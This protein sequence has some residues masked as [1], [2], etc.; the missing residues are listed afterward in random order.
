[1]NGNKMNNN[2][3]KI[4]ID[5]GFLGFKMAEMINGKCVLDELPT[6][7]GIGKIRDMGI[8]ST[9]LS[10]VSKVI[11]PVQVGL[12][13]QSIL[14][15]HNVHQYTKPTTRLDYERLREGPE[16]KALVYAILSNQLSDNSCISL[17]I[18]LPVSVMSDKSLAQKTINKLRSWMISSHEFT[19][20]ANPYHIRI[21]K[22]RGMAQPLGTYW[23]FG[24]N[25]EGQWDR[26]PVDWNAPVVVADIGFNTLDVFGIQKG[27]LIHRATSGERLGMHQAARAI[28]E[29]I[30]KWNVRPSL[31]EMDLMIKAHINGE[32]VLLY[33]PSGTEII[34][35]LVE[36]ALSQTFSS[37]VEFV[38]A[39]LNGL[40]YRFLIITGGGAMALKK[41][42]LEHYPYAIIL[43][44]PVTANA[45]GL[46]RYAIR[47]GVF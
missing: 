13:D 21:E 9:G 28:I 32:E 45:R 11:K 29:E 5:P 37:I 41:W 19:V 47:E 1:M 10:R 23:C 2:P 14:V 31:Y 24:L 35:D 8:L 22:V 25:K 15:G 38:D 46:A 4:A 36:T 44:D 40:P 26:S 7:T 16:I 3:R 39:R 18:G 12:G 6:V 27:Q 30:S 17:L 33:H 20:N 34:N 42:L 43:D